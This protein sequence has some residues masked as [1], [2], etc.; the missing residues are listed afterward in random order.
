MT[1][2]RCGDEF[3]E[4]NYQRLCRCTMKAMPLC[5]ICMQEWHQ[6]R[7]KQA[8]NNRSFYRSSI[9]YLRENEPI[10]F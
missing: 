3:R 5:A 2:K 6:Y 9:N 4:T 1:C 10:N 8:R 7:S